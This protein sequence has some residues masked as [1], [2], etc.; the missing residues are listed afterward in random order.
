MLWVCVLAVVV[1]LLVT[2]AAVDARNRRRGVEMDFEGM[3]V[4]RRREAREMRRAL[5]D[6]TVNRRRRVPD[7]GGRQ[8]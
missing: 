7:D 1:V 8:A 3:R 6:R 2:A 5:V 4:Q